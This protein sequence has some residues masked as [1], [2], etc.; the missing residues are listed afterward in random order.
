MKLFMLIYLGGI[1]VGSIGPLPYDKEECEA[2]AADKMA[3]GN[4]E[5]VTPDGWRL[6]DIEIKCDYFDGRPMLGTDKPKPL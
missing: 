4:P 3:G 1:L 6:K 5:V 2:R